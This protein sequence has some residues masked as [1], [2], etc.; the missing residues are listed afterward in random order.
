MSN[1]TEN[2]NAHY[3]NCSVEKEDRSQVRITAEIPVDVV[4]KHR[5]KAVKALLKDFE[6][7]GFRKGQVP[8]EMM[9][10]HIG[11]QGV[12]EEVADKLLGTAYA[13]IVRDN[14]LDVVG[15][16]QV[17]ITKLAPENPIAFTITVA[18][19]PE[20]SLPEYK[21]LAEKAKK[22]AEDPAQVSV[23]EKDVQKELERLHALVSEDSKQKEEAQHA[24]ASD[25]AKQAEEVNAT[26]IPL[27][28]GFAQ[29][30]G[31]FKTLDELREKIRE[32][33]LLEK[34]HKAYEKRRL[35]I[36]DAI[37]DKVRVDLPEVFVEGELEQMVE[38]FRERVARAGIEMK[39]Y[40]A[41]VQKTEQD[42]RNEWKA[43]AERRAKFQIVLA[44]IAKKE[45]VRVDMERLEREVAHIHEHYPEA[46]EANI[47]AYVAGQMRNEAVFD[48]L[49]GNEKKEEDGKGG[50]G[51]DEEERAAENA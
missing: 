10:Q 22:G 45:D 41:A 44:E 21:K 46:D 38:E 20:V 8:E 11:E 2:L 28:D 18:V 49:E 32:G 3:A 47:R 50:A 17:R 13:E 27:D 37:L 29:M 36:A 6:L 25:A 48:L 4:H 14:S 31:E 1:T 9:L 7:D 35:M 39:E 33:M 26:E 34:K 16:P 12:L 15:R 19:Y 23:P 5:G 43:D 40:L 30:L 42:M 24:D 51:K